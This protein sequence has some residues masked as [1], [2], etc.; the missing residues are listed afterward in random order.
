M[1]IKFEL[2]NFRSVRDSMELSLA[3]INYYKE[4]RDELLE[5]TLPGLSG[6]EIL[7]GCS[8]IRPQRVREIDRIPRAQ[9]YAGHSPEIGI[10]AFQH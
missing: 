3:A 5:K 10:H 4:H 6:G 9:N 8:D 1:L 7:A 2:E